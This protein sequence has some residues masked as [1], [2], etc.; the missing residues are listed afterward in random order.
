M[1]LY[2]YAREPCSSSNEEWAL[3]I[4]TLRKVQHMASDRDML[5]QSGMAKLQ[6]FRR[7]GYPVG[8]LRRWCTFVRMATQEYAWIEMRDNLR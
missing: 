2:K 6:E 7:L 3:V 4:A 1:R 5:V 8:M